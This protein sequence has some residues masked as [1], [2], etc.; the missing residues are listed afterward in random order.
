MITYIL[1]IVGLV[2]IVIGSALC[3]ITAIGLLRLESLY[4]RMHAVAKPQVLG[5]VLLCL[6][7]A[8]ITNSSRVG[9]TLFLVVVIQ[10][11]GAPISAHM[12]SRAAHRDGRVESRHIVIDEYQE[13][14]NRAADLLGN[15][16][17]A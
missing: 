2:L 8:L 14:I 9:A 1:Q 6:G 15:Q 17:P 3:L 4:S 10:F 16:P 5:T 11:L 12:L 7:L 13:D